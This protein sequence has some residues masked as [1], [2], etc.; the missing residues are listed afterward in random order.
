MAK[1]NIQFSGH[2]GKEPVMRY[3]SEGKA[4]LSFS[5]SLYTGGTKEAGYKPS[6]W[7][8]VSVWEK[9]AE[10]WNDKIHKGNLVSI[11]GIVRPPRTYVNREGKEVNVGLEVNAD[12]I[13]LGDVFSG[14][15]ESEEI[16]F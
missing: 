10:A 11:T 1:S 6:V 13:M 5:V 7:V 4:V 16:G 9:V 14:E 2:I 12:K 15:S 3:T 8:E